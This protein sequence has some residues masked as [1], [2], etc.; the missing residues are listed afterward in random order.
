M[1][2][3]TAGTYYEEEILQMEL[4]ILK[5]ALWTDSQCVY[6]LKAFVFTEFLPLYVHRHFTGTCVL[7]PP[8]PG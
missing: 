4:I 1:A 5:V 3:V 6:M 8:Y 7:K 2:D